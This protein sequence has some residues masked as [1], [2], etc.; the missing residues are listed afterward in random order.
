MAAKDAFLKL[1]KHQL[2]R[3]L[4]TSAGYAGSE[5]A[6]VGR[7]KIARPRPV[8]VPKILRTTRPRPVLVP[9]KLRTTRPRPVLVPKFEDHSSSSQDF[10]CIFKAGFC[11]L[12]SGP[13][14]V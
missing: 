10:K 1:I 7:P 6:S 14:S 4:A 5:Q 9:E 13:K 8:L 2:K 11:R 3:Q 12:V